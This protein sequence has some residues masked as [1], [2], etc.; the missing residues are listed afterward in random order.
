MCTYYTAIRSYLTKRAA[1][2]RDAQTACNGKGHGYSDSLY[3]LTAHV[4]KSDDDVA[5]MLSWIQVFKCLERVFKTEGLLVHN[6]PQVNFVL[7]EEVAQVLLVL[8]GADGNSSVTLLVTLRLALGKES[9][10]TQSWP[11][12]SSAA[13]CSQAFHSGPGSLPEDPPPKQFRSARPVS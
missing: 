1:S 11:P 5:S 7:R 10:L 13:E 2:P 4:S 12:F 3:D 6:R 8:G 9:R